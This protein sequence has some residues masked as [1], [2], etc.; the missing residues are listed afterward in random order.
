MK[1]VSDHEMKLM[2]NMMTEDPMKTAGDQ[3][4]DH[5]TVDRMMK[6]SA[7]PRSLEGANAGPGLEMKR[8]IALMM[9]DRGEA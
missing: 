9:I 2:R 3:P 6:T 7:D 1:L 4:S 5:T 8:D